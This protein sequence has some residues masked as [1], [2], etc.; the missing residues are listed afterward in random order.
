M[1]QNYYLEIP[2]QNMKAWIYLF[3]ERLASPVTQEHSLKALT[4]VANNEMRNGKKSQTKIPLPEIYTLTP[5]LFTLVNNANRTI[6]LAAFDA[7]EAFTE[8][9]AD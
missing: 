9:Y 2:S 6:A 4:K 5:Q 8:R 3:N 7:L 1:I